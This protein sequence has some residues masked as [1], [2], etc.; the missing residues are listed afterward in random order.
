MAQRRRAVEHKAAGLKDWLAFALEGEKFSTPRCSVSYRRSQ[1]VEVPDI[2]KL[3]PEF[4]EF[5]QAP[6]K[7]A[8][9]ERMKQGF[10]VDGAELVEKVS[11]TIK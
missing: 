10:M 1:S 11:V 5:K 3:D 9:K 8:I 7:K 6:K 4:I 2:T